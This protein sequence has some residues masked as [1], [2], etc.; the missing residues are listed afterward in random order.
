MLGAA[1]TEHPDAHA[2]RSQEYGSSPG[3]T[4]QVTCR[5]CSVV[6]AGN[7]VASGVEGDGTDSGVATSE[8]GR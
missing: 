2:P 5:T 4:T 8:V 1:H 3:S 6:G 7:A